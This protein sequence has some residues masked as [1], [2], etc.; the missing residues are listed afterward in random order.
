MAPISDPNSLA[1]YH[2]FSIEYTTVDLALD[3]KKAIVSG[4]VLFSLRALQDGSEIVLDT[5]YLDIQDVE[6]GGKKLK[7]HVADRTEH[8]GSPFT[9]QLPQKASKGDALEVKVF[10]SRAL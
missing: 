3:F 10:T 1:N 9:I 4:S 7:W 8:Y 6:S 5:S 2:V